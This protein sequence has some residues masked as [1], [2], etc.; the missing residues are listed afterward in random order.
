MELRGG[1]GVAKR[2]GEEEGKEKEGGEEEIINN[3]FYDYRDCKV[4]NL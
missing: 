3:W 1:E 2:V 4:Q